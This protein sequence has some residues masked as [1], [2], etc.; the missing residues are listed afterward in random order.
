MRGILYRTLAALLLAYLAV[1]AGHEVVRAVDLQVRHPPRGLAPGQWRYGYPATRRFAAFL[2]RVR[3]HVPP[4]SSV[5]LA[6]SPPGEGF[7]CMWA[8][9][10]LADDEVMNAAN[11]AAYTAADF[12]V[13]VGRRIH[14]PRLKL[15]YED[16]D[17]AVYRVLPPGAGRRGAP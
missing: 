17:G 14:H 5:A 11:P 6:M 4:G 2:D 16:V 10:L 8:A 15:L 1:T 13:A 12:W 3:V 9:Y 7:R